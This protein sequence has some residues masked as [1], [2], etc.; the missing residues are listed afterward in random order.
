MNNLLIIA[1]FSTFC[2]F[3][4]CKHDND[5]ETKLPKCISDKIENLKEIPAQNPRAEV[6]QW[7]V[8]GKTYYYITSDCCD[9]FNYLYDNQCNVVCA[10][11]GGITGAGDGACPKFTGTIEYTL[12]WKDP[13][14]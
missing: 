8:D 3:A 1:V 5:L 4:A 6:W 9:Q 11:D 10:P 12:V 14:E 13:R 7:K 2:V